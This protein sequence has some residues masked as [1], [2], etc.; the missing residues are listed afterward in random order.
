MNQAVCP[1]VNR[2]SHYQKQNINRREM[3]FNNLVVCEL[4]TRELNKYLDTF[5]LTKITDKPTVYTK[6][7]PIV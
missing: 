3:C 2:V 6:S 1:D 5:L 4:H 7:K